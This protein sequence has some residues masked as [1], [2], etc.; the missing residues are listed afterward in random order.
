MAMNTGRVVPVSASDRYKRTV[1]TVR[2]RYGKDHHSKIARLG[3]DNYHKRG[4]GSTERGEDGLT[5]RERALKV[6][7][8]QQSKR[9]AAK[10]GSS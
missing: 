9:K 5:G 2:K 4:F 10:D 6:G 3:K 1:E 8:N 7:R